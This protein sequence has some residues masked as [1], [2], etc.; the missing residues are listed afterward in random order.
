M[1]SRDA[2]QR[3]FTL[4]EAI[5]VTV[6]TGIL[7]AIVAV[8]IRTPVQGYFDTVRRA[9][10]TDTADTTLRRISRDLRLALPTSIRVA[11]GGGKIYLEF[12]Q[13]RTGGR[14]RAE[15]TDTGT[16]NILDFASG[17]DASFDVLGPAVPV[18]SGNQVVIYNLGI[19]GADAYAGDNRRLITS[20]GSV[21]QVAFAP[22]GTPFPFTSPGQRFHVV[23]TPVTYE[24]DP[25]AGTLRRYWNYTIASAQPTPPAGSTTVS[26][27]LADGVADCTF[28]YDPSPAHQRTG[29]VS[30]R[31]RLASEGETVNLFQQVHVSNVP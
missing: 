5:A 23:D 3:G 1:R 25:G 17:G 6:I 24:C 15:P 18:A 20:N 9:L 19:A 12:L 28:T 10:L 29:T 27:L 8:F 14:Y 22:T 7:A 4:V 16:G 21:T 30:L 2:F 13:T 26:A 31:L 11:S